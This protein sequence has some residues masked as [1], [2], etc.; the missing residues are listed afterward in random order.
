MGRGMVQ[1]WPGVEERRERGAAALR[2]KEER[3]RWSLGGPFLFS[4]F[5]PFS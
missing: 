1:G 3:E 5:L 4:F 2:R